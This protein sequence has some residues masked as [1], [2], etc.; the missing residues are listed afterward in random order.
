MNGIEEQE[1][2]ARAARLYAE[3]VY[4]RYVETRSDDASLGL[5]PTPLTPTI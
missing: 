5:S 1:D 4:A 3:A 2:L